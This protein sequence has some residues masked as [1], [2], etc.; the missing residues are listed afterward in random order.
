MKRNRLNLIGMLIFVLIILFLIKSVSV[1][2]LYSE[3]IHKHP[4]MIEMHLEQMKV[5][6]KKSITY[7]MNFIIFY[8]RKVITVKYWKYLCFLYLIKKFLHF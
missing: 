8:F 4:L 5:E 7:K 6:S 2:F 3:I 1:L